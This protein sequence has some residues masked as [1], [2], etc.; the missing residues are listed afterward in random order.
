MPAE[1][2]RQFVLYQS[3]G[4]LAP[5]GIAGNRGGHGRGFDVMA[6]TGSGNARAMAAGIQAT[7]PTMAG[8]VVA[9]SGLFSRPVWSV[10]R[11]LGAPVAR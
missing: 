2:K 10:V 4:A 3:A 8:L 7:L 6:V 11:N 9:L 5:F 1:G